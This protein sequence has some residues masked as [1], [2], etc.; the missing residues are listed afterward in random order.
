[1]VEKESASERRAA[2]VS[3]VG[4]AMYKDIEQSEEE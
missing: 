4:L 1:M 2:V 3:S